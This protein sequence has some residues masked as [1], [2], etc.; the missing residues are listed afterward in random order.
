MT[1]APPA[2]SGG[3]A[4]EAP[5]A[6]R[7]PASPRRPVVVFLTAVLMVSA[8][9][10]LAG[11]S[12]DGPWRGPVSALALSH[13]AGPQI[14]PAF[15]DGEPKIPA[16]TSP[17][18]IVVGMESGT[19]LYSH[20]A[21]AR[22]PMASTTKIMTGILVL[23]SL[24]LDA[25]VSISREVGATPGSAIGFQEGEVL[26]VRQ[27]MYALLVA[28]A[29]DAATALAEASAGS[30]QAFVQKMNEKARALGMINTHFVNVHGLNADKH[31][32]SAKDL[33]TLARYAMKNPEFRRF[34]ATEEYLLPRPGQDAPRKLENHNLLLGKSAWVTGV[35]TG[36]TPYA[37]N[38]LVASGTRDGVSVISVLLGAV[39][40]QTRWKES[41]A[42]LEYGF[43]LSPLTTLVD[44][45]QL[46]AEL[47]IGDHLA[48][49]IRL[50]A[51]RAL[52]VS[53]GKSDL[54][55]STVTIDRDIVLPVRAGDVFG[56]IEF[57]RQ[58]GSLASVPVVA[59]QSIGPATL[60]TILTYWQAS[61][62]P[63]HLGERL[64][65]SRPREIA[66]ADT[67]RGAPPV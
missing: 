11:V 59:A 15:S 9:M 13:F 62:P 42:L 20:N 54:V 10:L 34:V 1:P 58:G 33:A 25:K 30:V 53:L 24:K 12:S 47:P 52:T 5:A 50:V 4:S 41:K 31:F 65:V 55:T 66:P 7:R 63:L 37:R 32:S 18:A 19:I 48:R 49:N 43:S 45:G 16:I 44:K 22:L 67:E 35:K 60:A 6:P 27:L 26:T 23:E 56:K 28:S 3:A 14:E 40:D 39:Q 29:N 17:A 21:N 64:R 38:C 57:I 46:I 51:A 8:A 2:R 36:S 61:W